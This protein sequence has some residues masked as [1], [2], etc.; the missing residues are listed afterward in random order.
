VTLSVDDG[1]GGLIND[2]FVL[3]VNNVPPSADFANISGEIIEGETAT[4]AFS[5]A[6]DPAA[7]DVA[8]GFLYAYDCTDDGAFELSDAPTP[9]FVCDYPSSGS[10]TARGRI[11]DKDGGFTEYTVVITVL[12]PD[13]AIV[14]LVDT[15]KGLNLQQGIEN[16]LDAK[17]D[18]AL[19]ALDDL[20]A[21]NDIAAINS[22]QAFINAVETQRGKQLTDEQANMLISVAQRIIDSIA[23]A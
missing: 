22:L 10:F 19:Q 21:N 15:V 11:I 12:A 8:A 6:F 9:S 4:L 1:N 20:N 5:D 13:E 7:P 2:T 18:A 3:V 17:L 23:A 14:D 16:G